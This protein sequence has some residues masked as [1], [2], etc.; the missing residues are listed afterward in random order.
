MADSRL[1]AR[2]L[3]ALLGP[4]RTREPAYEALADAI[5]LLC[6][7]NRIAPQ[8]ALPAERELAARLGVS[9]TTVAAAYRSLRAS[10]HIESVRGSGSITR[11][12]GRRDL[13]RVAADAESTDLQQASPAAWPGLA[14]V[15]AE[16][17]GDAPSVMARPGYDVT[18][19]RGL[20]EQIAR[21][22]TERGL[23]TEPSQ[24]MVTNGAQSAISLLALLLVSRGDRVL[25]E[26]PTYPHAAEV[27]ARQGARLVGVPVIVGAGW[28]LERAE[29]AILRS[30]PGV[31]YLMPD[32]HNPTGESMA[33]EA[34]VRVAE[35]ARS[36]GALVI[37]DET[38]AELGV[39]HV[40]S[41]VPFAA[42]AGAD[43]VVTLGSLGKTVWGG[44]RIGWIRADVDLVRRLTAARPTTDL[45]TPEFEQAVA[46]RL[47]P[48]MPEVLRQRAELL[49]AGRDA[50]VDVLRRDLPEWDVPHVSG[51]VS[52]WVGLGA[53][54]SSAL[55]LA[56]RRRGLLLSAGPRF[57]VGG[58]HERHLRVPFTAPA[59]VLSQAAQLL[60]QAWHDVADLRFDAGE[61][62]PL[63]AVV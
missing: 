56:A 12:L 10:R 52:L 7:D 20:R 28:D 19:R 1:S 11:P 29:H 5:R 54:R 50:I 27:F 34:R 6:L 53:P 14:A 49:R 30:R 48:V 47:M 39:E 42:A 8:T 16:V 26:T 57:S 36:V 61:T 22:Y 44:L 63:D 9:R 23:P 51:G 33:P 40:S 55:T 18:G 43:G 24:V 59:P 3:D 58:G 31:V 37:V 25:L 35:L 21:R 38:T 46:E 17:A 13:G 41:P 60:V 4:W 2:A 45:G 62:A 15:Y 32:F